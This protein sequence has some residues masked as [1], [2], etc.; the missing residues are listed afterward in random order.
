LAE[1]AGVML[2]GAVGVASPDTGGVTSSGAAGVE[3]AWSM[4]PVRLPF[5]ADRVH[6]L[7]AMPGRIPLRGWPH[8]P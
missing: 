2:G 1:T 4:V 3:S 8:S 6:F 5:G 7:G